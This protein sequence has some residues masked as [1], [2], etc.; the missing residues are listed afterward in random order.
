MTLTIAE[1]F[2]LVDR[3]QGGR[4]LSGGIERTRGVAGALL[5]DLAMAGLVQV[6]EGRLVATPTAPESTT[7]GPLHPELAALLERIRTEKRR[8][9]PKW[10]VQKAESGDVNA[11]L[12][13]G[14][15][16]RGILAERHD[17]RFGIF[18]TTRWI[19]QDPLPGGDV[20]RR[21]AAVVEGGSTDDR[22]CALAALADACGLSRKLF[23][24]MDRSARKARMKELSRGEWAA[25][26]V[27]DAV[28]ATHSATAAAVTASTAAA[29]G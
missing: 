1:E 28:K 9:R 2:L 18:P 17:R 13:A 23:P 16:G 15:A 22:A 6:V 29:S 27:R 5:I 8:R 20:R 25:E 21:L 24:T 10:W 4:E 12:L 11:R 26:A 3:D 7:P 19:E 14:L